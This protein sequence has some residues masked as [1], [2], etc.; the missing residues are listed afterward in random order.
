MNP[1]SLFTCAFFG[2]KMESY[3]IIVICL[4]VLPHKHHHFG[5][6]KMKN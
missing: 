1:I 5:D 3:Q 4:G 6:A 2:G